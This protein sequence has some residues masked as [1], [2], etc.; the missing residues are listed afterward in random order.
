MKQTE[1]AGLCRL[2]FP[3]SPHLQNPSLEA[4][5]RHEVHD[6]FPPGVLQNLPNRFLYS[7]VQFAGTEVRE[8]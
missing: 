7:T 1:V 4:A 5:R 2:R 3:Y 6:S 8:V